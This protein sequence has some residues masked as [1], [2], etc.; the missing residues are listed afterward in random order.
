[1]INGLHL[2]GRDIATTRIVVNG[3]GA[4][5]RDRRHRPVRLSQSN[6]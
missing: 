4:R 3:A 1:L 6:Q 5:R 2:T